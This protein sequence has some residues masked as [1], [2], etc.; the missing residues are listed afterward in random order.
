MAEYKGI[1]RVDKF[2]EHYGRKGMKR[3]MNIYN[4]DY[5]PVGEKAKGT[6]DGKIAQRSISAKPT[7]YK[8]AMSGDPRYSNSPKISVTGV[9]SSAKDSEREAMNAA[10]GRA[11][12]RGEAANEIDKLI[13]SVPAEHYENMRALLDEN[14]TPTTKQIDMVNDGFENAMKTTKQVD[15]MLLQEVLRDNSR[16]ALAVKALTVLASSENLSK[17]AK[18]LGDQDKMNKSIKNISDVVSDAKKP[19][20][21]VENDARINVEDNTAKGREREAMNRASQQASK[22]G[23]KSAREKLLE[24]ERKRQANIYRR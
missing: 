4:P 8:S 5:K 23:A 16:K 19:R 11:T 9:Q 3:G 22:S 2:F 20:I 13:Q 7:T 21:K 24:A 17:K 18:K 12:A 10:A 6:S 15:S 1:D 14:Y